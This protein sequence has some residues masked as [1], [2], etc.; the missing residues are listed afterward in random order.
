MMLF[1]DAR[2]CVLILLALLTRDVTANADKIIFTGPEPITYP[3]AS[4]SLADLN[5]DVIG[6]ASLSIRTSLSRIF[7]NDSDP[8][9]RGK[10]RG[11]ASWF[12]LD[13][14][15]P[16]QRYELRVCWAAIEPTEFTMDVHELDKVWETPD[17]MLSL[18]NYASTRQ[19]DAEDT[20]GVKPQI[21]RRSG[22]SLDAKERKESVLL[23]QVHAAADYFSHHQEL[24]RNPPPV[25]VDLILDPYLFN[26]APESLIL[27]AGYIVIVAVVTFFLARWI[28][29]RMTAI[30]VFEDRGSKKRD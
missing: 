3:L 27:T 5:L 30:A 11:R 19:A 21:N 23:L 8:E 7:H 18:A 22:S 14:L 26:V 13:D 6:P 29:N 10:P 20:E 9:L 25:L 1:S 2:A 28:A 16:G 12:I 17:L 24:M 4:P 15:T